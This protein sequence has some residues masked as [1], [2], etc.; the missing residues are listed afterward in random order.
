MVRWQMPSGELGE[1]CVV[2]F[3]VGDPFGGLS[4][5][6]SGF[7]LA[8]NGQRIGS[9]E[10]V[11]QACRFPHRPEWQREIVAARGGYAAKLMAQKEKRRDRFSR[12]DWPQVQLLI[13]EW[14]LRVKLA[15]NF[16]RFADLLS[17][18]ALRPIV[19]KSR[20]DRFWAAV[21]DVDGV[22]RG[23]NHLGRLL[24]KLRQELHERKPA[25]LKEVSPLP[26]E[27]FLLFGEEIGAVSALDKRCLRPMWL[28][29]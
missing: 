28:H 3:K 8:V 22:L 29:S 4:N 2:V 9:G 26:I 16:E 19:E 5:M 23:E 27:D 11:Y 12:K 18:S 25:E 6:A 21:E 24:M 20:R 14:V 7:S 1:D 17:A 10:A 13:M 15:Q